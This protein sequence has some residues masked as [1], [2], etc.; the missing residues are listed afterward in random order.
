MRVEPIDPHIYDDEGNVIGMD[1]TADAAN[2][3]WI[4][5]ARKSKEEQEKL[6]KK[7]M[8]RV[9]LEEGDK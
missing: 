8:V 6:S 2:S 9:Y 1:L 3:D 7:K 4:R 5:A